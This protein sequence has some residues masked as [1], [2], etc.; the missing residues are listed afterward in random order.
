[1]GHT[2]FLQQLDFFEIQ[3]MNM[4]CDEETALYIASNLVFH[5]RTKRIEIDSHFIREKLLSKEICIE[6][7]GSNDQLADMLTNP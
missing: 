4:Y 7:V 3:Q 1:M 6:F 2:Q 5:E